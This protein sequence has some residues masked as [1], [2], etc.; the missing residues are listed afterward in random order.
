MLSSKFESSERL[1]CHRWVVERT[2]A[3]L[4]RYRR[5]TVRYDR[6][7]DIYEAFL[8]LAC[9]LVCLGYLLRSRF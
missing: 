7:A 4:S 6:C 9:S 5:L 1:G 3:W 2:L 8:V